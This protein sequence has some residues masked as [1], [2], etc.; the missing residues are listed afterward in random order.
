MIFFFV[1]ERFE[2]TFECSTPTFS[3]RS[4][5]ETKNR[6]FQYFFF[7]FPKNSSNKRLSNVREKYH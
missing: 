4:I 2:S 7:F 3:P 5:K 6:R 1:E